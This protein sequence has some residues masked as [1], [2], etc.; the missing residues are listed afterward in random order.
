MLLYPLKSVV[1]ERSTT[2]GET[3]VFR[4]VGRDTSASSLED[5]RASELEHVRLRSLQ[6]QDHWVGERYGQ[7]GFYS[8]NLRFKEKKGFFSCCSPQTDMW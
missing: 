1:Y 5:S 7:S 4:S 2:W 6:V 8:G 3:V